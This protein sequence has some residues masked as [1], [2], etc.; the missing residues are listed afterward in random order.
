MVS[1]FKFPLIYLGVNKA[2]ITKPFQE[3]IHYELTTKNILSFNL[4]RG[5]FPL[6][7]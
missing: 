4:S 7:I 2:G 6:I 1:Y 3:I 5:Y